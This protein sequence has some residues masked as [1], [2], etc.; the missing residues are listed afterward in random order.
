MVY[1]AAGNDVAIDTCGAVATFTN[2]EAMVDAATAGIGIVQAP[3]TY[4]RQARTG[5]LLQS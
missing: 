4:A 3:E 1:S 5:A 2:G